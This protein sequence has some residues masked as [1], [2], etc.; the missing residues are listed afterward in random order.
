MDGDAEVPA[1]MMQ[2]WTD[3]PPHDRAYPVALCSSRSAPCYSP[4]PGA[5]E[6][7]RRA[8]RIVPRRDTGTA[9]VS[10]TYNLKR[11]CSAFGLLTRRAPDSRSEPL[12]AFGG[13]VYQSGGIT[14]S[15]SPGPKPRM[16]Y[17][18]FGSPWPISAQSGQVTC[19]FVPAA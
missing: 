19:G 12:I 18:S 4:V 3:P 14:G 8:C 5:S 1:P 11:V 13:V 10:V 2:S 7:R 16:E 17:S 15:N 6:Q 9:I